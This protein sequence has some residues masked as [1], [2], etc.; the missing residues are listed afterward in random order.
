MP[1]RTPRQPSPDRTARAMDDDAGFSAELTA[2]LDSARRRAVRDGDRQI[3]TAH[4]LHSLLEHDPQV[5]AVVAEGSQLARLLGYLVQRSIGYGLRWR[6]GVEDSGALPLATAAVTG[7]RA[8]AA[9][10]APTARPGM[11]GFSPL[12][13]AALDHARARAA[14]RHAEGRALPGEPARGVDLLTAIVADPEARAVEVLV[15][16]GVDPLALC[17]RVEAGPDARLPDGGSTC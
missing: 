10:A 4:L 17:A 2:T 13:S 3:D 1:P 15:R 5:R 16:A 7:P 11:E 12:A 8:A 6:S 9:R 14:A